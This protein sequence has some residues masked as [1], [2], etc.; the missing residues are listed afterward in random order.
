MKRNNSSLQKSRSPLVNP[1]Q[2]NLTDS[3]FPLVS[4]TMDLRETYVL[5]HL[6]IL[7]YRR[8][9][10]EHDETTFGIQKSQYLDFL[11]YYFT[12]S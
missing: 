1:R 10:N 6:K 12:H 9:F 7:G 2:V 5:Y 11:K 8:L 4:S 3:T